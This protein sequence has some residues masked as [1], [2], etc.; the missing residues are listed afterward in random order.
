MELEA[1]NEDVEEWINPLKWMLEHV[2]ERVETE[3]TGTS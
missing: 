1:V 2:M 3:K